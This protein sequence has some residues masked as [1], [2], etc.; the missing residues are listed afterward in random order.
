M[1]LVTSTLKEVVKASYD[2]IAN[3][4]LAWINEIQ[5]DPRLR[6]LDNLMVRLPTHPKVLD[7][8]CGAGVPCTALL[9]QHGDAIGVDL[10]TSQIE[11]A[12]QKVPAARFYKA[13]MSTLELPPA[14]FD[15][16]TAFYS[17]A[18]LPRNEHGALFQRIAMWLRPGGHFLAAL[19]TGDT[20]GTIENWLG[21]PMFFSSYDTQTNCLLLNEAGFTT[22]VDENVTMQEPEGPAT[23]QW[24]IAA[25]SDR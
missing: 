21:A 23:F 5:G 16:V 15:A 3:R 22:L 10:S 12:R 20:H 24:V 6:F 25:K 1:R 17:I 7:L 8:G 2:L 14:S 11:L 9:A 19:G 18:H 13:D 4:Y